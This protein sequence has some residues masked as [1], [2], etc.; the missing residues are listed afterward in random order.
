MMIAHHNEAKMAV[1]TDHSKRGAIS[2]FKE[3]LLIKFQE[4]NNDKRISPYSWDPSISQFEH[5]F[6]A[7]IPK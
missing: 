3:P 5:N 2:K 6:N 1:I 4:L 7:D